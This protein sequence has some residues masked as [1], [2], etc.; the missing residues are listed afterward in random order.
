MNKI[1]YR[2]I[3]VVIFIVFLS[4]SIYGC[5][6]YNFEWR[7]VELISIDKGDLEL[8]G[9]FVLGSGTIGGTVYYYVYGT[10]PFSN[11][12]RLYKIH[13]HSVKI[14]EDS[15]EPYMMVRV[16]TNCGPEILWHIEPSLHIPPNTIIKEFN[17]N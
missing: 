17:M 15:E 13:A 10:D 9:S 1:K 14:Y 3:I 5:E 7:K 2:N 8:R 11:C 16:R 6:I 12:I 4:L